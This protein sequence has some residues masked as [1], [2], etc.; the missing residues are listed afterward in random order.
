MEFNEEMSKK[1]VNNYLREQKFSE[2][3]EK[4]INDSKSLE[5]E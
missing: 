2:R 4:K 5:E 3:E 1:Y